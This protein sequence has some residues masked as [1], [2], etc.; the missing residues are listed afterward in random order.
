MEKIMKLELIKEIGHPSVGGKWGY[1]YKG[2]SIIPEEKGRTGKKYYA[3]YTPNFE[4]IELYVDR[5][6][7]TNLDYAKS[8]INSRIEDAITSFEKGDRKAHLD[9][10]N[11]EEVA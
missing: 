1:K 10:F 9:R 3:F 5:C 11:T 7:Y 8:F 4:R 6:E 2:Y